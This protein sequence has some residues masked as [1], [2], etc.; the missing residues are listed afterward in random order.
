MGIITARDSLTIHRT[1]EAVWQTVCELVQHDART[2]REVFRLGERTPDERIRLLLKDLIDAGVPNEAARA[3]IVP[4]LY[5]PFDIRYTFYTGVANGFHERPRPEVMRHLLAGENV[6]LITTRGQTQQEPSWSK[7]FITNIPNE[8][9]F[10]TDIAY[11]FPLYLYETQQ[12]KQSSLLPDLERRVNLR[13][14]F[15]EAL[16]RVLGRSPTPEEALGY[17]YAILHSPAYRARYAEFL[18]RDFPRAPLPPDAATFDALTHL[19]KGLI[20]LHLLRAPDLQ[21]P[22]CKYPVEGDHRV[23]RVR[24]DDT[25]QR[26][27]IN[28]AQYFEPVPPEVWAFRVGGYPVCEKWLQERKGTPLSLDERLTYQ[29]VVTAIARTLEVQ[30]AIDAHVRQAWGW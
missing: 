7:V 23:E 10:A 17:L 30:K 16:G 5:R 13:K 15:L 1:P 11:T 28:E 9:H 29:K 24:Y 19:G 3:H 18:K 4:I 14:E 27:W 20:D 21:P 12:G 6:A 2:A 26:V 22:L 25:R 8:G